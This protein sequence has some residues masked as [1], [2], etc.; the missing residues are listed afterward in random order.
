MSGDSLFVIEPDEQPKEDG[1]EYYELLDSA[2]ALLGINNDTVGFINV[3][4]E[5]KISYPVVQRKNEI[6]GNE[7]YLDKD[8]NRNP[9]RAGAIFMDPGLTTGIHLTSKTRQNSIIMSMKSNAG[10]SDSPMSMSNT[11]TSF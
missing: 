3:V 7:Y 6:D 1:Y 9:A 2:K 10:L 5:P 4:N 8:F 11:E